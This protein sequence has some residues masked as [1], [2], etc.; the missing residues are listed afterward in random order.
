[1]RKVFYS[2]IWRMYYKVSY[3]KFCQKQVGKMLPKS[4][5]TPAKYKTPVKLQA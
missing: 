5:K 1:M 2:L 4:S 3:E